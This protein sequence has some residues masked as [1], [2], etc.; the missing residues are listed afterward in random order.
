MREVIAIELNKFILVYLILLVIL[1][2][3]KKFK[4]NQEKL[5]FL[6]SARMSVQLFIAGYILTYIIEKPRPIF[7]LGYFAVMIGFAIHRVIVKNP[8]LNKNFKYI[9][10]IAMTIS[11]VLTIAFFICIIVGRNIF[12]PQYTIPISGMLLGNAM[13]GT[14]LAVK[15]FYNAMRGKKLQIETLTNLG[16]KPEKI[17]FPFVREAMETALIPTLNSMMGMGIVSLPGMMTGQILSGTLP[18]V[19]ILYQISIMLAITGIVCLCSL[20]SLYFG[21][22][23]LWDQDK[24]INI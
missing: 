1:G 14:T 10:G 2:V 15:S 5:L 3:M 18:S 24:N 19:A 4:I 17:L 11:G 6:G 7:T 20:G 12:D 23:T 8:D 9:I 13:N 16:V 21:Q 22:K